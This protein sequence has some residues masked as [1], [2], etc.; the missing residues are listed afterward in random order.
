M[1]V[2]TVAGGLTVNAIAG[3][4]VVVLGLNVDDPLR[5]G[6]RGF[7]IQREDKTEGETFWMKGMKTFENDGQL[8]TARVA[9]SRSSRRSPFRR[10][11]V[12]QA[13]AHPTLSPVKR[14]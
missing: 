8:I 6:L 12:R 11:K 5:A 3:S 10:R 1:R 7:A 14:R 2:R 9:T 4:Y 13:K